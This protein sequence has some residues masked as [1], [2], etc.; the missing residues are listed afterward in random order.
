VF[1]L[2]REECTDHIP[3]KNVPIIFLNSFNRL[4]FVV[5]RDSVICAAGTEVLYMR[6]LDERQSSVRLKLLIFRTTFSAPIYGS[7]H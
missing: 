7:L 4:F 6:D 1:R 5:V 3:A 2:I